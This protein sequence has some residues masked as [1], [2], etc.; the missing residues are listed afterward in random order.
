MELNEGFADTGDELTYK[1]LLI[2]V[3]E[4]DDKRVEKVRITKKPA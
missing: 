2:T 1:D 4:A 3:L